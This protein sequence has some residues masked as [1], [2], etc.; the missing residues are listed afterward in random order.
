MLAL[1]CECPPP[2]SASSLLG[3]SPSHRDPVCSSVIALDSGRGVS[4]HP[5]R[6]QPVSRLGAGE[7]FAPVPSITGVCSAL[8][9]LNVYRPLS[10]GV[11]VEF[12]L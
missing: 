3:P 9:S 4:A 8:I 1:D 7:G 10:E 6:R 11:T 5:S 12:G 2:L